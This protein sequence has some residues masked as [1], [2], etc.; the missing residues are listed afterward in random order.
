ML[1]VA[2]MMM[3][4]RLLDNDDPS[5][6]DDYQYIPILGYCYDL[7]HATAAR[8]DDADDSDDDSDE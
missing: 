5:Y 4:L 1:V 6:R 8:D 7:H 3:L 2:M